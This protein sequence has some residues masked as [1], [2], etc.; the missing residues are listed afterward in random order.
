V[1][2]FRIAPTG[3]RRSWAT[4]D[5]IAWLS[6]RAA[7]L[8]ARLEARRSCRPVPLLRWG[9]A[10]LSASNR[11]PAS[12]PAAKPRPQQSGTGAA[13]GLL[14]VPQAAA[15]LGRR[16]P[17]SRQR[18]DTQDDA[19]RGSLSSVPLQSP[20]VP[21]C[22]SFPIFQTLPSQA[23]RGSRGPRSPLAERRP[24]G[25]FL[26]SLC[27]APRSPRKEGFVRWHATWKQPRPEV[28]RGWLAPHRVPDRS[29]L[30]AGD[31]CWHIA[32]ARRAAFLV[33]GKAFTHSRR[34]PSSGRA[35]VSYCWAGTSGRVRLRRDGR[36]AGPTTSSACWSRGSSA[37]RA[38]GLRALGWSAARD[39]QELLPALHPDRAP[40]LTFRMDSAHPWLAT[41]RR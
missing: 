26:R 36:P 8:A 25:V 37:S 17:S 20:A 40:R 34:P 16:P 19:H 4:E 32:P 38:R 22:S 3:E 21:G 6:A 23:F 12:A 15:V 1:T 13:P 39:A 41:T 29:P 9:R 33:G 18:D 5:W 31:A 2:K 7:R 30:P 11:L 14:E 24:R 35:G 10:G 27:H 28:T